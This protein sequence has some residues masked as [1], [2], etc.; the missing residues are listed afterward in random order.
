MPDSDIDRVYKNI[1]LSSMGLYD[2]LND[3][4]RKCTNKNIVRGNIWNVFNILIET[5][6]KSE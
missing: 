1:W 5:C 2:V 6:C 3:V 4:T